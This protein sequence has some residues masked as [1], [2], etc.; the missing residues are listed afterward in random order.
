[1]TSIIALLVNTSITLH[2]DISVAHPS[3]TGNTVAIT[4]TS[5]VVLAVVL[6]YLI[7]IKKVDDIN[8]VIKDAEEFFAQ[9]Y[10]PTVLEIDWS[11]FLKNFTISIL[12][13][14]SLMSYMT[15]S[16][17]EFLSPRAERDF[18]LIF[19]YSI[20][21]II[22]CV[23]MSVFFCGL[24]ILEK[25][26]CILNTSL[27]NIANDE[28]F[29][30]FVIVKHKP[31]QRMKRFCLLSD[32]IDTIS[33]LHF[34][35]CKL[36]RDFCDAFAMQFVVCNSFTVLLWIF[37]LFLDYLI[38]RSSIVK[39]RFFVVPFYIWI[40]SLNIATSIVDLSAV[41][42]VCSKIKTAYKETENLIHKMCNVPNA[43]NRFIKSIEILSIQL[44]QTKIKL[45]PCGLYDIDHTLVF[46]IVS[47][48]FSY[49]IIL[50]QFDLGDLK[51]K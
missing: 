22:L 9:I 34:K 42:G 36:T 46:S 3:E 2:D 28:T 33:G 27:R 15:V 1:M 47:A 25:Y 26:F 13:N 7:Q 20:P 18:S 23:M 49:L 31:Y 38:I 35:L 5:A 43:D 11:V 6:I 40:S 19:F 41:A 51:A 29:N 12:L 37:K 50:V 39:K 32:K 24:S 21:N 30:P 16:R 10:D 4:I 8:M 44:T 48:A 45:S 14:G 17:L